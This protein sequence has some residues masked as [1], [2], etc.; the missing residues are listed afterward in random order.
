MKASKAVTAILVAQAAAI[1]G[2]YRALASS[3]A[4]HTL[5]DK[6]AGEATKA[7]RETTW[8][9]FKRAIVVAA[10]NQ[11]SSE[12]MRAGLE[13]ACL[14]AEIPAGSFRGYISTVE[15]LAAEVQAGTLTAH[16]ASAMSVKDARA[17]YKPV[18]TEAETAKADALKALS[19]VV[20]DWTA[21]QILL[22]CDLARGDAEEVA[23]E[24]P[25]AA[26][27]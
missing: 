8:A 18:P 23:E 12:V 27:G 15:F 3:L 13:L 2:P 10:E 21:E 4:A 24:A 22:L 7:S 1:S 6:A 16:E 26:N 25:Q 14:D 19:E 17:R 11:H 9:T 20:K 5:A